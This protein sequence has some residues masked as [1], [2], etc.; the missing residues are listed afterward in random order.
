MTLVVCTEDGPVTTL[1]LN[2]PEKMNA[3]NREM[4]DQLHAELEAAHARPHTRVIVIKGDERAFSTGADLGQYQSLDPTEVRTTNLETWMRVFSLIEGLDE[5]VVACVDG[6]AVA[7]GTELI[8]ACDLVVA[9]DKARFGLA[10]AKVGVIPGAGACIRLTRWV[11]RAAAKEILMLGNDFDAA[12]AHR[13]G[14]VNRVV[15]QDRLHEE[16]SRLAHELASRSP[17]ALAAAKRA[18][19]I[20]S[21]MDAE[22]GI[23]YALDEFAQLFGGSDQ[24]EG[25]AAFLERRAPRFTGE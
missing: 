13:L 16:T 9:S 21:E 15:P 3:F 8:L 25:M 24:K 12:E 1:L 4:L 11:G 20:G 5:P 19:N 23:E 7:G 18:V 17:R 6:W 14:L 22:R 10:E 2:R